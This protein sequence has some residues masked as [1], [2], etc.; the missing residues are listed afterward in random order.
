MYLSRIKIGHILTP[1]TNNANSVLQI[2]HLTMLLLIFFFFLMQSFDLYY[3]IF[4][5]SHNKEAV[6]W[7]P[8]I[9]SVKISVISLK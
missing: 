9:A 7:P 2:Y 5:S 3:N 6:V 4:F 8:Q 1:Q